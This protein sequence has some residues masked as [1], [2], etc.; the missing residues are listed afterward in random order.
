MVTWP[1]ESEK[2]LITQQTVDTT[3]QEN[4]KY[5]KQWFNDQNPI[6][7]K[8]NPKREGGRAGGVKEDI[9]WVVVDA[10]IL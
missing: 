1:S 4:E 7:E 6:A 5:Q 8:I 10:E 2:Q 9:G 3:K